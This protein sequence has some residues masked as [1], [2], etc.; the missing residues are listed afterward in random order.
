ML[1]SSDEDLRKK[2]NWGKIILTLMFDYI[3]AGCFPGM[4][5]RNI[6]EII[7]AGKNP[8][9]TY[10]LNKIKCLCPRLECE[11][12]EYLELMPSEERKICE[13]SDAYAELFIN[14]SSENNQLIYDRIFFYMHYKG[15]ICKQDNFSLLNLIAKLNF[16][17]RWS[18]KVCLKKVSVSAHSIGVAFITTLLIYANGK[19]NEFNIHDIF[20][21]A[22]F[23]DIREISVGDI[24]S[25]IKKN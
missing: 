15:T 22:L 16:I 24:V 5:F 1:S 11:Y 2:L 7:Q 20:F 3:T 10:L 25:P 12:D 6:E 23:H 14:N 21:S 13:A 9:K 18:H 4:Y 17:T 8:V 19:E